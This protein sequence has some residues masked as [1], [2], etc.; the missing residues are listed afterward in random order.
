MISCVGMQIDKL[1]QVDPNRSNMFLS[2]CLLK[3]S[4]LKYLF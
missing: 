3:K 1:T 4:H 2:Q